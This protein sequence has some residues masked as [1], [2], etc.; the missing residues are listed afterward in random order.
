MIKISRTQRREFY[1][2]YLENDVGWVSNDYDTNIDNEYF[3]AISQNTSGPVKIKK[4]LLDNVEI[5]NDQYKLYPAAI[6]KN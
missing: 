5:Q 2:D 1:R 3:D 4:V 6:F